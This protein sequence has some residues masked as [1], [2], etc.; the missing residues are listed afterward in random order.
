M[1]TGQC[2]C[3]LDPP[4]AAAPTAAADSLPP[5]ALTAPAFR[6]AA[7]GS[8][9]R[10]LATVEVAQV[11]RLAAGDMATD[12][13]VADQAVPQ[14]VAVAVRPGLRLTALVRIVGLIA[15]PMETG[16][17][18]TGLAPTRPQMKRW[19]GGMLISSS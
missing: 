9:A 11:V 13:L 8:E 3:R 15:G 6:L 2:C 4:E 16:M 10:P 7:V 18:L 14:V 19:R 1:A 5:E 12:L 17:T